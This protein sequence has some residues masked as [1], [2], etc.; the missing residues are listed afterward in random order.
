MVSEKEL[1][2]KSKNLSFVLDR[3]WSRSF[4]PDVTVLPSW[5]NERTRAGSSCSD[6]ERGVH[7][8][9]ATVPASSYPSYWL[10]GIIHGA[11]WFC[12]WETI[13]SRGQPTTHHSRVENQARY[14]LHRA[15]SFGNMRIHL[16]LES[17]AHL[18]FLLTVQK[19]SSNIQFLMLACHHGEKQM[20][21]TPYP[22]KAE[23]SKCLGS[24]EFCSQALS[25]LLQ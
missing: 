21:S 16:E 9:W 5:V 12:L 23:L 2:K 17:I 7:D 20:N 13:L 14:I 3:D 24:G 8:S 10:T 22:Y 15:Y 19:L 6:R 25:L 4:A 18:W 11:V 1:I